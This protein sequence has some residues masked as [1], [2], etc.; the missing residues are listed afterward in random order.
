MGRIPIKEIQE[1]LKRDQWT[2]VSTEYKNLDTNLE[3]KCSEGHVVFAPWREIRENRTCP[4]CMR[5]RLKTKEFKMRRKRKDEYRILAI[6]QATHIS[7]FAVYNNRDLVDYGIFTAEGKTEI[8]RNVK[9]KQWM[10]SLIDTYDIDLVGLEGIQ[11]QTQ[12]GVTT[13]ETLAR[14]QGLLMATCEEE[15]V[16]YKVAPTGTWRTHCGV[17]GTTRPDRKRSMQLLVEQWYDIKPTED[18][19][20]AIGIGKYF[21]DTNIP[22]VEIVNWES[23]E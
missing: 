19:C 6:D 17:K 14:L 2:L 9:I 4:T 12:V 22:K 18:E 23:W 20:D 15:G 1:E 11:Y 7:G 16:S 10:L 8:A 5:A 21:V 13:F 3:Y